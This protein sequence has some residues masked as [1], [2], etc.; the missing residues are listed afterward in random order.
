MSVTNRLSVGF[1]N[2]LIRAGKPIKIRYF[3]E[4]CGS[5]WDDDVTLTEVT[6]SAIWTSGIVFPLS[7]KQG[8][9]DVNLLEQGKLTNMDQKLYVNGSMD[10]TGIGSNLKVM[11][12]MNGSPTQ[13]MNYTMILDGGIPYEVE[14]NQI[15]K[16]IYIRLLNL[17]SLMG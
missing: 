15:Y 17:G 14:G 12:G 9:E 4:S 3:S 7:N 10:F 13:T 5:V 6:G 8:S 16:K 2:M 11:I 1:E